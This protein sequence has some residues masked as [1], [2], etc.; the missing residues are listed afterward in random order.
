MDER[1]QFAMSALTGMLA[2]PNASA[3]DASYASCAYRM[4]DAMLAARTAAGCQRDQPQD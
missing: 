1:D 3:D 4:A 2:N